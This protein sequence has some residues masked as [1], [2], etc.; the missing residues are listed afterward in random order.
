MESWESDEMW[1][2][3]FKWLVDKDM[4]EIWMIV[5]W[6]IWNNKNNCFHNLSCK[7]PFDLV[8]ATNRMKNDI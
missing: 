1:D 3:I 6:F 4:I 2:Q 7:V 5:V 8:N